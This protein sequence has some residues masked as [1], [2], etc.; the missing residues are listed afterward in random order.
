MFSTLASASGHIEGGTMKPL[1]VTTQRRTGLL[2]NVP[3]VAEQGYPG[4]DISAWVALVAPKGTSPEVVAILNRAVNDSLA[5]PELKER[6]TKL[7]ADPAGGTPEELAAFMR[8]DAELWSGVVKSA[9]VV[10]D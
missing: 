1:A 10:V 3:T 7:G 9:K 6:L 2:P 4:Y 5:R 8:K